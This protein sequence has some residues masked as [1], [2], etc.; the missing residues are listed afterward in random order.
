MSL[1]ILALLICTWSWSAFAQTDYSVWDRLEQRK[2]LNH[3]HM[4]SSDVHRDADPAVDPTTCTTDSLPCSCC[5][6]Q[7]V[8][9]TAIDDPYD[10]CE[11]AG[12]GCDPNCPHIV[13]PAACDIAACRDVEANLERTVAHSYGTVENILQR[14][15]D[16]GFDGIELTPHGFDVDTAAGEAWQTATS[17]DFTDVHGD[18]IDRDPAGWPCPLDEHPDCAAGRTTRELA[19]M[20]EQVTAFNRANPGFL[21]GLGIEYSPAPDVNAPT[22]QGGGHKTLHTAP[23]PRGGSDAAV[24]KPA[25]FKD[26]DEDDACG[27][28]SE[29]AIYESHLGGDQLRIVIA[30]HPCTSSTVQNYYGVRNSAADRGGMNEHVVVGYEVSTA[31]LKTCGTRDGLLGLGALEVLQSGRWFNSFV[32]GTDWHFRPALDGT[33]NCTSCGTFGPGLNAMGLWVNAWTQHEKYLAMREGRTFAALSGRDGTMRWQVHDDAATED[34]IHIAGGRHVRITDGDLVFAFSCSDA[35]VPTPQVTQWQLFHND[36]TTPAFSGSCSGNTCDVAQLVDTDIDGWYVPV[37]ADAGNVPRIIGSPVGVN[38]DTWVAGLTNWDNVVAYCGDTSLDLLDI[39]DPNAP[40]PVLNGPITA[41]D[42]SEPA[43]SVFPDFDTCSAAQIDG[44][45]YVGGCNASGNPADGEACGLWRAADKSLRWLGRNIVNPHG[46][47]VVVHDGACRI[48]TAASDPNVAGN[49]ELGIYD[50]DQS[51]T[52]LGVFEIGAA[53]FDQDDQDV[54]GTQP[55]GLAWAEVSGE[56]WV[57]TYDGFLRLAPSAW[58]TQS[59]TFTTVDI[60]PFPGG[61]TAGHAATL[62]PDESQVLLASSTAV[63]VYTIG[64]DSWSLHPDWG[65]RTAVKGLHCAES[66]RCALADEGTGFEL[67]DADA[68]VTFGA[69]A[70]R[71]VFVEAGPAPFAA[72]A[73]APPQAGTCSE[74]TVARSFLPLGTCRSGG[75]ACTLDS[76]CTANSADHCIKAVCSDDP[77]SFCTSDSDCAGTCVDD[78]TFTFDKAYTCGQFVNGD[79]WV[80]A[81]D[82]DQV[83]IDSMSPAHTAACETAGLTGCRNGWAQDLNT[84]HNP[85]TARAFG[86]LT[87]SRIAVPSLPATISG[88]TTAPTSIIKAIDGGKSSCGEG[89]SSTS[90]VSLTM[91]AVLTIVPKD[92]LPPANAFRPPFAGPDKPSSYY[93]TAAVDLSRMPSVDISALPGGSPIP[94]VDSVRQQHDGPFLGINRRNSETAGLMTIS[95]GT[96]AYHASRAINSNKH[97]LRLTLDDMNFAGNPDH[98]DALYKTLQTGIDKSWTARNWVDNSTPGKRIKDMAV[99]IAFTAFVMGDDTTISDTGYP[100]FSEQDTFYDNPRY[101]AGHPADYTFGYTCTEAEYWAGDGGEWCGDPYGYAEVQAG[102]AYIQCCSMAPWKGGALLV[103]LMQM[104]STLDMT[105][106]LFV[107]GRYW[108]GWA[109]DPAFDQ[110]MWTLPDPCDPGGAPTGNPSAGCWTTHSCDCTEGG[111]GARYGSAH[112]TLTTDV[113]GEPGNQDVFANDMWDTF[114]ACADAVEGDGSASAT[115]PCSGMVGS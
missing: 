114:R 10:C 25:C 52:A 3:F 2:I 31:N 61:A 91:A 82:S 70:R 39:S 27:D 49:N 64:T 69:D 105:G 5:C 110:G 109:A 68:S 63:H 7:P 108:E 103:H 42:M 99:P 104:Q 6:T 45:L 28:R 38:H 13:P 80:A 59:P 4:G 67:V 14:A 75:A 1:R 111:G 74:I 54:H 33:T 97:L 101:G 18:S 56:L 58:A 102:G 78:I 86:G 41:A 9:C 94:S 16:G 17:T 92:D 77:A 115:F 8:L 35:A 29:Q 83:V 71:A 98:L 93:T 23:P 112:N 84:Q 15:V 72:Q 46:I 106:F 50:C 34:A 26:A 87:P 79:W 24:A 11:G 30:A 81:D 48:V 47:E 113:S 107:E 22:A 40:V 43:A 53:P 100:N 60:E 88:V 12:I 85:F 65:A 57:A 76:E 95:Q 32:V 73:A 20:A 90:C 66:G 37:C 55:K 19:S 96:N 44:D 21:G 62:T 51:E 36:P 89:T